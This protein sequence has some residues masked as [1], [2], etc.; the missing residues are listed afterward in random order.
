MKNRQFIVLCILVIAGFCV[1]YFQNKEIIQNQWFYYDLIISNSNLTLDKVND[2]DY[3]IDYLQ[4]HIEAVRE[5][6]YKLE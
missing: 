2:M 3:K 1:L 4:W 5:K 6:V